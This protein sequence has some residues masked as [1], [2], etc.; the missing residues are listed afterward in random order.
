M[1]VAPAGNRVVCAYRA[2]VART[3]GY[4]L[5]RSRRRI[6]LSPVV[7]APAGDG[8]VCAHPTRMQPTCGNG[9]ERTGV[10]CRR[11]GVYGDIRSALIAVQERD[12][13]SARQGLIGREP[14]W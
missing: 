8:V 5:K 10:T 6:C 7:V 14:G 11:E 13:V 12:Q 4:V 9:Y 3:G 2:R 1:V